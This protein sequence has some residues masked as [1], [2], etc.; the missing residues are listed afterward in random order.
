GRYVLED[1][2]GQGAMG[3]VWRARDQLAEEARARNPYVAVKVL[4]SDFEGHAE[5]FVAMHRE[6]SRAHA[7]AHPNIVTVY[8][9]DRDERSGRAF[10]AMELLE[11]QPL[12]R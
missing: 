1:P 2:I 9:F 3:Q 6:A 7:L 4:N 8:I 5:A 10:I 12:D 11:G